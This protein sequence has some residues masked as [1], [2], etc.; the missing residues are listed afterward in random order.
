[1]KKQKNSKNFIS[2]KDLLEKLYNDGKN[3]IN[4]IQR[5]LSFKKPKELILNLR[6]N[7][8]KNHNDYE[9]Q[10]YNE[11][12]KS[13]HQFDK[14]FKKDII[15]YNNKKEEN[16]L[17]IRA[18][19]TY[20]KINTKMNSPKKIEKRNYVFGN[21]LNSYEKK[22]LKFK[23]EFF[24]NDIYKESGLL[25]RKA[26]NL[27]DYFEKEVHAKF[28]R[29]KKGEKNI[30]FLKKISE[31]VKKLCKSNI[32]N[33]SNKNISLSF[34]KYDNKNAITFRR[35]M[36]K[37][38][39]F[40]FFKQ[41]KLYQN[42]IEKEEKEIKN[43]INNLKELIST[44]EKNNKLKHDKNTHN[45]NNNSNNNIKSYIESYN[46]YSKTKNINNHIINYN[47]NKIL[48][49]ILGLSTLTP[50]NNIF[51]NN[52][53]N[54]ENTFN[55]LPI[56]N[57]NKTKIKNNIKPKKYFNNIKRY[58]S[59]NDLSYHSI[60]SKNEYYKF[61]NSKR[62]KMPNFNKL[63]IISNNY[64]N[65]KK[66]KKKYFSSRNFSDINT[67]ENISTNKTDKIY[68]NKNISLLKNNSQNNILNKTN[69]IKQSIEGIYEKISKINFQPRKTIKNGE[70]IDNL[71]KNFYG[72]KIKKFNN[73][74]VL[75]NYFNIKENILNSE[76]KNSKYLKYKELLYNKNNNLINIT[77][78]QNEKLKENPINYIKALYVKRF[79]ENFDK[80]N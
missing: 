62:R 21:L 37:E 30:K 60:E 50:K 9:R 68:V 4:K 63:K 8:N 34:E 64:I 1:M 59:Y 45:N 73:L 14:K 23:K 78:E 48:D 55:L 3:N 25:L 7:R 77:K 67:I 17:F 24:N 10:T 13:F 41:L 58:N 39:Y 46:N 65:N 15:N 16:N 51:I 66:Y 70:N 80:N 38:D 47:N 33:Q 29:S 75:M 61:S 22:G 76:N 26:S 52:Y 27:E 18:Y 11:I 35:K 44:E 36:N 40:K 57:F 42:K 56:N 54:K 49:K 74:E 5:I 19:K 69:T 71:Y 43:E 31:Q 53:N 28:T 2:N 12:C 20:T 72:D 6:L 32:N 79:K